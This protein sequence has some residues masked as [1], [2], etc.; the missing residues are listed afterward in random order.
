MGDGASGAEHDDGAEEGQEVFRHQAEEAGAENSSGSEGSD[1][2][3]DGGDVGDMEVADDVA[4]AALSP[5]APSGAP[6]DAS[7]TAAS[8]GAAVEDAPS[9]AAPLGAAAAVA[10][11]VA[12][13]EEEAL[14]PAP[15]PSGANSGRRRKQEFGLGM[16]PI[17]WANLYPCLSPL[18][19]YSPSLTC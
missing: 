2:A 1:T 18:I 3:D 17:R 7:P 5:A 10:P 16:A 14:L 8:S 15:G 9:P 12:P 4:P 11:V 6:A 13:V 19:Q